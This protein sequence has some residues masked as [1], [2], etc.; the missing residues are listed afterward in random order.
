MVNR[1]KSLDIS[2][3]EAAV[4]YDTVTSKRMSEHDISVMKELIEETNKK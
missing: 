4:Q 2:D 3:R 1:D